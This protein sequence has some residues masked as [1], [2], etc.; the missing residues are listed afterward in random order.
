MSYF[1][2]DSQKSCS[3][4]GFPMKLWIYTNYDCNLRCTYC[5]A[6]SSPRAPRR[7]LGLTDVKRLVDEAVNLGF[8]HLYLTGG[9]PLILDEIYAMADYASQ[10]IAT[11]ILTNAMLLKGRRLE[12]L[13][14]IQRENLIIQV[15][16]DGAQAEHHDPYRGSGSWA[17][18]TQGINRLLEGGFRV[19]LATTETP[20]NCD[21]L[22]A[23][24]DYHHALGI[25]EEDH[26][27]RP[28]AR[29]G[30]SREGVEVGVENLVPE[31]TVNR[32][33]VYWHPLSTDQD[34]LVR[35]E[36]FPLSH[37]V[38][39]VRSR[40]DEITRQGAHPAQEFN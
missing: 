40:L 12:K 31:I 11:T 34:L 1:Q 30:F 6:E 13:R 14:A 29:R 33:G 24:C 7:A 27:V 15:S 20:A 16:L 25:P 10:R 3:P 21:H 38:D 37:A 23:I 17:K 36:I 8:D 39:C 32:D 18:T 35:E 19:R 2:K 5:V 28:L 26:F 4:N 9:E 22:E